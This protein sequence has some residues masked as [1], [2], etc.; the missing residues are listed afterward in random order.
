VQLVI[1]HSE[2]L[3]VQK[4]LPIKNHAL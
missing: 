1:I 3:D 2:N 4:L